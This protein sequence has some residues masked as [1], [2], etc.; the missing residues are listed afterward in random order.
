MPQIG[1]SDSLPRHHA[2]LH[3]FAVLQEFAGRNVRPIR[4]GETPGLP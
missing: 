2:L 3:F 1:N 4:T